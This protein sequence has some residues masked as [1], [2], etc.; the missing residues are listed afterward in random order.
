MIS[1]ADR[2][3]S[4]DEI[5]TAYLESVEAGSEPDRTELLARYP[6]WAEALGKFFADQD[7]FASFFRPVHAATTLCTAIAHQGEAPAQLASMPVPG[8]RFGDY[9]LLEEI[10]R[11]GMGVVF[12]AR[13]VSLS[14]TVALKMIL[15]GHLAGP[16]DIQRF[17]LEAE[18]AAQLDHPNIVPI[19]EVGAEKGVHYYTMKLVEGD[20]LSTW[21]HSRA[22]A[23]S[24]EIHV[25]LLLATV[26][27][28]VHHAHQRGVLHRDLKPANILLDPEGQ[29]HVADF[30]LAKRLWQTGG[31]SAATPS[32]ATIGTPSYMS[33]EQA[34]GSN[35]A[36]TAADVYSLGCI[37]YEL[38]TS[39]PP[40]R[41]E[42][43]LATLL[44]VLER[45]PQKPSEL[46][47]G[48]N[49]DLETICLMCLEKEP[50]RR[51]V[52]AGELADELRRFASGEPIEAR[53]ASQ[54]ERMNR[55]CR[56]QPLLAATL[57][58]LIVVGLSAFA[59]VTWQ[60][61]RAE[62]NFRIS[63]LHEEAA[64]R[65]KEKARQQLLLAEERFEDAHALVDAF[66]LR[67]SEDRLKHLS[68]TQRIRKDL[69]E[70]G[71]RYY[72]KFLLQKGNDPALRRQLA[73]A[74][75]SLA[76][77]LVVL[78][79]AGEALEQLRTAL[80]LYD[81]LLAE[82]PGAEL[83]AQRA[84]TL[85]DIALIHSRAGRWREAIDCFGQAQGVLKSLAANAPKDMKAQTDLAGV[86]SNTGN[87]YRAQGNLSAALKYI[88]RGLELRL[89]IAASEPEND[90][91][92]TALAITYL[93]Y[94]NLH[95]A[96]NRSKEAWDCYVRAR[97]INE[98]LVKR[99]PG[100]AALQRNL[101][102]IL[103][104]IGEHQRL[105]GSPIEARKTLKEARERLERLVGA[106][107][108]V[109]DFERE[110]AEIYRQLGHLN[111]SAKKDEA[112]GWYRQGTSLLE[113]ALA[114]QPDAPDVANDLAKCWYDMGTVYS[115]MKNRNK[116][117]LNAFEQACKLREKVVQACPD[118]P[119]YRHD[120][121]SSLGNLGVALANHG[122]RSEGIAAG[123]RAVDQTRQLLVSAPQVSE[124]RRSCIKNYHLLTGLQWRSGR[125]TEALASVRSR[126]DL[127][128][129][130]AGE[131]YA[132][133]RDL[134]KLLSEKL[135]GAVPGTAPA[136]EAEG[137]VIDLLRR[138]VAAGYCDRMALEREAAFSTL[139]ERRGFQSLLAGLAEKK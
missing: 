42:T 10:G 124:Y 118:H 114:R 79:A 108:G 120:L 138:A 117:T 115:R 7:R 100:D 30:G 41:A 55:W 84:R 25:A 66:C 22:T 119:G 88:R 122:R 1:A 98:Q 14:R 57:A 33:P 95:V 96:L 26:A 39:H 37:L 58:A 109:V 129:T 47:S 99:H 36:T 64:G 110:L 93:N 43:P 24:A 6:E 132:A 53:P 135:Q 11:G 133:A 123:A 102:Q 105:N 45:S 121:A 40:F 106:N 52:S 75:H 21:K 2:E 63:K 73:R 44:E 28:A 89:R 70:G 49:R 101:A 91:F 78:G 112:L 126:A 18:S 104:L 134:G 87:L 72:R 61:Q 5:L 56:K 92:Q 83:H 113:K 59:L 111:L 38:L 20:N 76:T 23:A 116:E 74:H 139:R 3:S 81:Q 97:C 62:H 51:Y 80:G 94:G 137:L 77:V 48:L 32:G 65:E 130:D 136:A 15:A 8:T 31:A 82:A 4:L 27:D 85:N 90:V 131:L 107:P 125:W 71:S 17:R 69:L 13:Q 68:G 34:L 60:W 12:K 19:H 54:L 128:P 29:P 86:L 35:R 46:R 103:K 67:L 9:E 16:A 127:W 50:T